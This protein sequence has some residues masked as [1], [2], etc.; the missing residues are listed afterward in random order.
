MNKHAV[1]GLAILFALGWLS[2]LAVV[3]RFGSHHE[4]YPL[5]AWP[6][7]STKR[8][9]ETSYFEFEVVPA[10][11]AAPMP[12]KA[13]CMI[14]PLG[15]CGGWT[16]QQRLRRLEADVANGKAA[17]PADV[18][19]VWQTNA[20]YFLNLPRP[21]VSISLVRCVRR[22][23]VPLDAPASRTVVATIKVAEAE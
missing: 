18:A 3:K 19:A 4:L 10:P 23:D 20:R 11:G 16:T 13:V 5:T 22:L 17:V 21:P 7:F 6:M 15:R 9:V 2:N 8:V 1:R 12:L 14:Q